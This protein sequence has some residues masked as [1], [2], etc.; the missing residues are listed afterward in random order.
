MEQTLR[1]FD[2]AREASR[3]MAK[4][5]ASVASSSRMGGGAQEAAPIRIHTEFQLGDMQD[6]SKRYFLKY[7]LVPRMV[8]EIRRRMLVKKPV[9]GNLQVPRYCS[10]YY[11]RED[12][13]YNCAEVMHCTR[14]P[15]SPTS[16]TFRN[17]RPV[18]ERNGR[19]LIIWGVVSN[20]FTFR[21]NKN[22]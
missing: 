19:F 4:T 13:E 1:D 10:L 8:A 20:R 15:V 5:R 17:F 11:V 9:Q 7:Q 18:S 22:I 21:H 12:G 16:R 2:T 14:K 3:R 6:Y